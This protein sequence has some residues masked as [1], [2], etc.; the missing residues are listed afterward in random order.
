MSE[1][2]ESKPVEQAETENRTESAEG[3]TFW[4]KFTSKVWFPILTFLSGIIIRAFLVLSTDTGGVEVFRA[5]AA[6]AF[7]ANAANMKFAHIFAY[8]KIN[9]CTPLLSY[10]LYGVFGAFKFFQEK[11]ALLGFTREKLEALGIRQDIWDRI[12]GLFLKSPMILADLGIAILIYII[13]RRKF[14]SIKLGTIAGALYL[15]MPPVVFAFFRRPET[16]S[17]TLFLILLAVVIINGKNRFAAIFAAIPLSLALLNEINP[18]I[19][20]GIMGWLILSQIKRKRFVT[21][22]LSPLAVVLLFILIS[23]PFHS[24]TFQPPDAPPDDGRIPLDQLHQMNLKSSSNLTMT[25]VIYWDTFIESLAKPETPQM[26]KLQSYLSPGT[27]QFLLSHKP[28]TPPDVAGVKQFVA[29]INQVLSRKDFYSPDLFDESYFTDEGKELL[30]KGIN[31]LS[32]NQTRRLNKIILESLY[33]MVL[34]KSP[35]PLPEDQM[36]LFP[37]RL[38]YENTYRYTQYN[39]NSAFNIWSLYSI[40]LPDSAPSFIGVPKFTAGLI[41]TIAV[42]ILLFA[43]YIRSRKTDIEA[44]CLYF[45]LFFLTQFMLPTRC[46]DYAVISI[47]PF[48]AVLFFSDF[49]AR[50]LTYGFGVTAWVNLYL[51]ERFDVSPEAF[52]TVPAFMKLFSLINILMF[53]GAVAWYWVRSG[54]ESPEEAGLKLKNRI[55]TFSPALRKVSDWFLVPANQQFV[56]V[57][58]VAFIIRIWRLGIPD[59]TNFD[60]KYYTPMA[61]D[62]FYGIK[63]PVEGASHP[64]LSTY[65]IGIGIGLLG[66]NVIGWRIMSLIFS[67]LMLTVL[68]Y[69]AR[70]VFKN[71]APALIATSLLA[72]DFM[73]F[74]HSRLG[75]LDIYSSF[76]NLCSYYLLYLFITKGN[77]RY[78]WGLGATLAL[79]AACKWTAAFTILGV[80]TILVAGKIAGM[81][82]KEKFTYGENLRKVN[83]LKLIAILAIIPFV[84]QILV[85]LPLLGNVKAV[86]NKLQELTKYHENLVGEDEIA[87]PWWSWIFVINPITYTRVTVGAPK[88][89]QVSDF[90]IIRLKEQNAVEQT[91][92][93]GMGNPIA[94][95]FSIPAII[96]C[97]IIAYRRK[98]LGGVYAAMPFIFQYF[99][100]A[101]IKR[102]TYI[103]YMID[104]VPY[105]CLALAYVLY[106]IYAKGKIGRVL[107][108]SYMGLIV[109]AFVFFYPV[110][111]ALSVSP[112]IYRLYKI[113]NFWK[114]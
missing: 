105:M 20:A 80:G 66:D 83:I 82:F 72:F 81:I 100:W 2:P 5:Q 77:N 42:M 53:A 51:I 113:F 61:R 7:L 89:Q 64:P 62:Y 63:D 84:V 76:F 24:F 47:F 36:K 75:M 44:D 18:L 59:T 6:Q 88:S 70:E 23:A 19:M 9:S 60:E 48:L 4:G 11:A 32:D 54:E 79:G 55:L 91:A 16:L 95:W 30:A 35:I 57:L 29:E 15:L 56:M 112:A 27:V 106:A 108:Y 94:W 33:P 43:L 103:F 34:V 111:T 58:F 38:I 12:L 114:F 3:N 46:F 21:A 50:L 98:D 93:T 8:Y 86:G 90:E 14:D 73:H 102:I 40:K 71:H 41:L 104:I 45:T 109:A 96:A 37:F 52:T 22:A 69:F 85:F 1:H 78:L 28:E 74:V 87:S 67:M 31:N 10:I 107:V 25:D 101:F 68:Y 99:P 39:S 17:I 13:I 97:F 92:V 65:I 26:I 49:R 110:L